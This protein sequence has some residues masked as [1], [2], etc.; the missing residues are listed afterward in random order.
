MPQAKA[1]AHA[2]V[3][4]KTKAKAQ[5]RAKARALPARADKV[6]RQQLRR[7]AL[8]ELN[9]LCAELELGLVPL[10][11]TE[12]RPPHV[13]RRIRLLEQRC[14]DGDTPRRLRAAV[15][16]FVN[17]GGKLTRDILPAAAAA[18]HPTE[19]DT[20]EEQNDPAGT[21]V[22]DE[23]EA[24]S[25]SAPSQV[26]SHRV[27]DSSFTLHSKA[28]MLTYNSRSFT[29]ADWAPFQAAMRRLHLELKSKAWAANLEQSL[30]ARGSGDAETYHMHAY[31]YWSD[32]VG[33]FRRNTDD[34]VFQGV[35][36]RVDVN[37]ATSP[38]AFYRAACHGL[39]YVSIRKKGT[40]KNATNF[41]PWLKYTPKSQWLQDLWAAH[42]LSHE[43][44]LAYSDQF[45]P[46]HTHRRRDALDALRD[47]RAASVE[48]HVAKELSLLREAKLFK[49]V[50]H[51]DVVE[52]FVHQFLEG[53]RFR[54]PMLAVVGGT[55][56]GK[57]MLAARI[58]ERIAEVLRV[59]GYLE[60][61]VEGANVLDLTD[62]DHR[63][64]AG[65]L[66]DGVGDT[67]LL[68][69]HRKVL[70]GRPKVCKGGKSETMVYS[71]PFTLCKRAV[72]A[73]LDL[74]ASNLS[75][76]KTD[77]WLSE[78]KNVLQLHLAEPAWVMAT[79]EPPFEAPSR[80]VCM[81][82]WGVD[83][84][85]AFLEG[86]DLSGPASA[87]R[88]AGVNGADFLAWR[89]AAELVADLVVTPFTARKVLA[90]RDKFLAGS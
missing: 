32:G 57:S 2:R 52:T 5:A 18:M 58:L 67:K 21:T 54:R 83:D 55:N 34:F 8:K 30:H 11:Q 37:A 22:V 38:P 25:A 50:R 89:S 86:E 78:T 27:L 36:P 39:W 12:S 19:D 74:S 14:Q 76:L 51:F 88:S 10:R 31:F 33:V 79:A 23:D 44:Y 43:Q 13:T 1:K 85:S 81:E 56:L 63:K 4:A 24:D 60:V 15:E 28:C 87:F 17:N 3:R 26:A 41:R 29:P 9:A 75:K 49:E 64:H 82:S 77:H 70:Q 72:V 6:G 42:K 48:S 40:L 68:K 46:G 65:V 59:E 90:C 69:Q 80:R 66:L 84:L 71:Y 7:A 20:A 16:Q 61:S 35:H 45:G 47:D 73:T 62:F 53:P